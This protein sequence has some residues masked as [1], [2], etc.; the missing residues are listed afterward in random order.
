MNFRQ[1]HL[2]FHTSGEIPGVGSRFSKKDFQKALITGHVNQIT[3]F[4]KCHHGWAYFPSET[5]TMHPTLDFDLLGEEIEAA[6]E[7]GVKV[8]AYLSVGLD[9]KM[10]PLMSSYTQT[11]NENSEKKNNSGEKNSSTSR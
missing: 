10:V 1:V 8:Q 3:V 7:I 2:D 4:A 6:H 5:N 11:G 9:E